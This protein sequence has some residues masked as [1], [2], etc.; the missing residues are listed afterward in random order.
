MQKYSIRK[1][2]RPLFF[3]LAITYLSFHALHGEQGIYAL[4]KEKYKL[5]KLQTD[6]IQAKDDRVVLERKVS[7]LQDNNINIDM[8]EEQSRHFL[9]LAKPDEMMIIAE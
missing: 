1:I 9:G 8:L 3:T 6:I 5:T 2:T 4:L 7:L